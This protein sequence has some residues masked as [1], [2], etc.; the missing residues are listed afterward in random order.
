M[1][2]TERPLTPKVNIG[3]EPISNTIWGLD[4][5]YQSDSR[6]LTRMVDKIPF[7][8]TKEKSSITF[9]GEFAK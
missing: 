6:W 9:S 5:N 3:D 8:S 2:L 7:I 4:M 1:N